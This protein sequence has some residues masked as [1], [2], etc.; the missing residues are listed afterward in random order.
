MTNKNYS[1]DEFEKK[2][3]ELVDDYF[4]NYTKYNES[5]INEYFT[6]LFCDA[7]SYEEMDVANEA[8]QIVREIVFKGGVK[9]ATQYKN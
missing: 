5:T 2:A 3:E 4:N 1:L 9:Y 6:A 8:E 7:E